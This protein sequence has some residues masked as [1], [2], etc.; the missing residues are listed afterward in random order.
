MQWR[1]SWLVHGGYLRQA[2]GRDWE[3][4]PCGEVFRFSFE[5]LA[6][7]A[8]VTDVPLLPRAQ[9]TACLWGDTIVIA[10]GHVLLVRVHACVCALLVVYMSAS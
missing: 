5:T 3:D 2:D 7:E 8:V 1:D 9:H 4:R 6:W 10:G